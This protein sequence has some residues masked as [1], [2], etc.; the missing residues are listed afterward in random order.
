MSRE[1]ASCITW[2]LTFPGPR[3]IEDTPQ[4]GAGHVLKNSV[5]TVL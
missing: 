5:L 4:R 3:H 1:T 2:S